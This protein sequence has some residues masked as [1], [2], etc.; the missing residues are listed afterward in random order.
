[1]PDYRKKRRFRL[2][3]LEYLRLLWTLE[4]LERD[5]IKGIYKKAQQI[6]T[7]G[8]RVKYDPDIDEKDSDNN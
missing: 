4:H 2:S 3:D 7:A 8:S 1:M 5:Q 6:L